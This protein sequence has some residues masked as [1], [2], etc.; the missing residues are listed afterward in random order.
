M[1]SYFRISLSLLLIILNSL[2]AADLS[3]PA[4]G[5]DIIGEP[6]IDFTALSLE[7]LKNVEIISV[8]KKPEKISSAAAAVFVITQEDIRRS[9]ATTIPDA[10]RLAPGVQVAR[11]NTQGWAVSVR[12]F[13]DVYSNK[14]LVLIDGR[15]VYTPIFSGVFWDEQDM[16][17]EDIERIEVIRGPGSTLWGA[18]AVN[19]VI[20]I[21]TKHTE[22]T[23]GGLIA[24]GGGAHERFFGS[25]RY[26]DI[27]GNDARYRVYAKYFN[28]DQ[29]G[30]AD[31]DISPNSRQYNILLEDSLTDNWHSARAGFRIDWMPFFTDSFTFQG[32]VNTNRDDMKMEGTVLD[33]V[34]ETSVIE[35]GYLMGKWRHKFSETSDALFQIYYDRTRRD[36]LQAK[37]DV[38]IFDMDFQHRFAPGTCHEMTYGFGY[39]FISDEIENFNFMFFDPSSRE[40][41]LLSAFVQD[42]IQVVADRL[43][44][45]V[46]SKFEH[47]DFSGLEIQPSLRFLLTLENRHSLWGAV[48]RAVRVPGR[49]EH[50]GLT[51]GRI[52]SVKV[53]PSRKEAVESTLTEGKNQPDSDKS[54]SDDADKAI[55][56]SS[57][58]T[59]IMIDTRRG[60]E[61]FDSEEVL[62]SELG[63]RFQPG[64]RLWVD[65][66][67]FYNKY[68][69]LKTSEK[70][71]SIGSASENDKPW[72]DNG[73]V[74]SPYIQNMLYTDNQMD[75]ESYGIEITADWHPA[76]QWRITA[77]YSY[78]Q[79]RMNLTGASTDEQTEA[80]IEGSS[81]RH[82][83]SVHSALDVTKNLELD[84]RLRYV[85][86]LAAK[87][88][89][90]YTALD[91]RLAWR[92]FRNL[93]L[94]VTGQNLFEPGH[95]EFSDIEVERSVY[96]KA[97][98]HF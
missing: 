46:G 11:I 50:D 70:S 66:T 79:L 49:V 6:A 8:S 12:G 15:S 52:S 85:D 35:G 43:R 9:G 48:S 74:S 47:N 18:N 65:A 41:Y 94:S 25:L 91:A 44:V 77:A 13:G 81:P 64:T 1:K 2:L 69:N 55:A 86:E 73:F 42:E 40:Q 97:A 59:T 38:N 63:Y 22:D 58:S 95:S 16:V 20:N 76:D 10:L 53:L 14:L 3:F 17:L 31:A 78:L 30:E 90:S 7:E 89:D 33:P 27:L 29:L 84:L 62:A 24:A 32:D 72:K 96:G 23:Q 98:W 45:T 39:R 83:I 57:G 4:D 67:V 51:V 37:Y 68:K 82:Q 5:T 93:E 28:R 19:G 36:S 92:P 60:T 75:G 71:I 80:E 56:V 54:G 34:Y 88:T 26:G 21:I 61:D 87:G